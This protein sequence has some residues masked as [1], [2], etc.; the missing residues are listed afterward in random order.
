MSLYFSIEMKRNSYGFE[1]EVRY[2]SPTQ[3]MS[4]AIKKLLPKRNGYV[5]D[6]H[7]VVQAA[8]VNGEVKRNMVHIL[9]GE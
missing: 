6:E 3:D 7:N 8:I 2:G 1:E 4:R 5:K 9:K